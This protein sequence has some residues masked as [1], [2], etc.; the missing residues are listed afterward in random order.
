ME[1]VL[2]STLWRT[3]P[4]LVAMWTESLSRVTFESC[5][6]FSVSVKLDVE[7]GANG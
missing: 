6:C 3:D 1:N 2:F 5:Q 4:E 7:V